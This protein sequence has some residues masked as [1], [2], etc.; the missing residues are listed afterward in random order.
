LDD[1]YDIK[2]QPTI[3]RTKNSQIEKTP[4]Q[5][6]L[7]HL[8]S[9]FNKTLLSND[10]TNLKSKSE[11]SSSNQSTPTNTQQHQQ[12]LL[13]YASNQHQYQQNKQTEIVDDIIDNPIVQFQPLNTKQIKKKSTML[14][15]TKSKTSSASTSSIT[16]STSDDDNENYHNNTDEKKSRGKNRRRANKDA[17]DSTNDTL[18]FIN[19]NSLK[20]KILTKQL[21][22]PSSSKENTQSPKDILKNLD[23]NVPKLSVG[24]F[25]LSVVDS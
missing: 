10:I 25:I 24:Y 9:Y 15:R 18:D 7:N 6:I 22:S 3:V 5:I 8:E 17:H 14:R 23:D 19:E 2:L 11:M 13:T 1:Y 4:N 20:L 12:G 16:P 21:G